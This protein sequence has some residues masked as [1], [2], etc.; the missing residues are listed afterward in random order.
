M[1]QRLRRFILT[2][3]AMLILGKSH[4]AEESVKPNIVFIM[5]DDMGYGQLGCYGQTMIQTPRIDQMAVE[6][7]LLT[8][9][10]AGTAVCAP[11]RNALMSGQHVGHTFIRGNHEIKTPNP[12][13]KGQLPI[14]DSTITVAE[15]MKEAGYAT[16][17]VGK[18]GL[19]FPGSEGDPMNQGFDFFA[20]Y[21]CQRLAHN[22]FPGWIWR[23][24]EV[25]QLGEKGTAQGYSQH[26]L[27]REARHFIADNKDHPFFLYLAYAIPHSSLQIP[28]DDPAYL[29][30][31]ER[32]WPE[33]QKIHAG[34][35]SVMDRDVG[36]IMDLL[37]QLGIADNTLVVFTS[38][39][40]AHAEGGAM[41]EFFN[42]SGPLRGIK[43]DMY[44]GG[45]RVPFI[46][47]WPGVIK[48]GRRSDHVG[49]HWDLMPTA[50]ELAS[51][52]VPKVIDGI[53]YVPL[54][55]GDTANQAKHE[56]VYFELHSPDKRGLR[57][58]DWVA[59]QPI[60]TNS[61][62]NV[63]PVELY[64][65]KEDLAQKNDLAAQYPELVSGFRKLL[66]EAHT[67]S[68]EFPFK[69]ADNREK[70]IKEHAKSGRPMFFN[71]QKPTG[72]P[73]PKQDWK[74]VS[75][76]SESTHN[77]RTA[78]KAIDENPAT[79]WHT[80]FQPSIDPHPHELVI[81]LHQTVEIDGLGCY[82]RNDSNTT[83]TLSEFEVYVSND[84]RSFS[85][86]ADAKFLEAPSVGVVAFAP[87]EARY[88]KLKTRN[89]G[90]GK[91]A[92]VAEIDVYGSEQ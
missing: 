63:D 22:H 7:L 70:K 30:Y 88:V 55:K 82:A 16:A 90:N 32:D 73:L 86:V 13:R 27:T 72:S 37:K 41:P 1:S 6:G 61:D 44:E 34:M 47:W 92:C 71:G 78:A 40:G 39:N 24:K 19:G 18:W 42:D 66:R 2:L 91:F 11:S 62:P 31:Q 81:D 4:A 35:I 23:N 50:C 53:S 77:N 85:K 29:M 68:V 48:E 56:Y 5:A 59:L 60:A 10:Y 79:W 46:A 36:G 83:G 67:P 54:L 76:S 69:G 52:P 20:G 89:S 87:V 33:K 21:N 8:D 43:R 65:L 58:G 64:N 3:G 75:A 15:K 25:V 9:Y 49:A 28:H 17:L 84:L 26:Y 12:Q 80:Q 74:V 14:P 38:D 57:R 45:V 51:V